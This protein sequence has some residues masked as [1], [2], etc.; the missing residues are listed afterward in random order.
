MPGEAGPGEAPIL[1]PVGR[2]SWGISALAAHRRFWAAS[3]LRSHPLVFFCK[4]INGGSWQKYAQQTQGRA[5]N[6]IQNILAVISAFPLPP[7][8][9]ACCFVFIARGS[10]GFCTAVAR[11]EA[12]GHGNDWQSFRRF[13]RARWIGYNGVLRP[14]EWCGR[15]EAQ[16]HYKRVANRFGSCAA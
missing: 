10:S 14:S 16:V 15:L 3:D 12:A 9:A 2:A 11:Q 1:M 4:W 6:E 13:W 8:K 7:H 5:R